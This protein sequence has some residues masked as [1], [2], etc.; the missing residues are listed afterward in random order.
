MV[1]F[2]NSFRCVIL[3]PKNVIF[4][5][6]VNSLYINGDRAEYELLAYHYPLI[7][8]VQRGD[9][10]IDWKRRIPVGSG[11]LR[12]FANEC[13]ILVEETDKTFTAAQR[14]NNL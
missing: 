7:G 9:I 13:T 10:I 8:L 6:S 4:E 11:I 3:S 12:F 1:K 5:S 2:R 14:T